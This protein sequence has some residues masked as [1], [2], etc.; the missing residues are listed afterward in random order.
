MDLIH[1]QNEEQI[2]RRAPSIKHIIEEKDR[3][4]C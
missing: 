3:Q 1:N 4:Y 2:T